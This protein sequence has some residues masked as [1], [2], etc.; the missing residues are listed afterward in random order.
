MLHTLQMHSF[1]FAFVDMF[2]D[3][4]LPRCSHAL[5][6]FL[7]VVLDSNRSPAPLFK[8]HQPIVRLQVLIAGWDDQRSEDRVQS[9]RNLGSTKA[10]A[11]VPNVYS[12]NTQTEFI[13]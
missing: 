10:A 12:M 11:G 3:R 1:S 7:C 13:L 2:V 6:A 4:L 8:S 9:G 5:C